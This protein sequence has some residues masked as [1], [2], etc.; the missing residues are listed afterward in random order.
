MEPSNVANSDGNSNRLT[1]NIELLLVQCKLTIVLWTALQ[2]LNTIL[3]F[4][5]LMFFVGVCEQKASQ[6]AFTHIDT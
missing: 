3:K 4:I 6:L 1:G 2:L 5:I